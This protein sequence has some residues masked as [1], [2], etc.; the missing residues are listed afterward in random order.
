MNSYTLRLNQILNRN[1]A[2]LDVASRITNVWSVFLKLKGENVHQVCVVQL[3]TGQCGM[4]KE[5]FR[6]L[7]EH[8]K[9]KGYLGPDKTLSTLL[10]G[11]DCHI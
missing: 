10:G 8:Y 3:L 4:R 2:T 1:L 9:V 7:L 5:G 6:S 11:A